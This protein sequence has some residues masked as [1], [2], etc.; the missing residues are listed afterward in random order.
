[1]LNIKYSLLH[2][3]VL[4]MFS[5]SFSTAGAQSEKNTFT[6]E[7]GLFRL[8]NKQNHLTVNN[9][10]FSNTYNFAFGLSYSRRIRDRPLHY[11]LTVGNLRVSR[12]LRNLEFLQN[13]PEREKLPR[14]TIY[15]MQNNLYAIPYIAYQPKIGKGL[16]L[17]FQLGIGLFY[18]LYP[19][20][21]SLIG[22]DSLNYRTVTRFYVNIDEEASRSWILSSAKV[23]LN[24]RVG[25][26][27]G[28]SFNFQ[29]FRA[30]TLFNS[31]PILP[32]TTN[33]RVNH[34]NYI[35]NHSAYLNGHSLTLSYSYVF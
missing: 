13:N 4:F 7:A 17:N 30:I 29:I 21:E 28:I 20:V 14:V 24:Y 3:F 16:S 10:Y 27:S 32:I 31:V 19:K 11:G 9:V 5:L 2:Y 23:G 33:L 8:N 34:A 1:M 6:I 26:R 25:K 35:I 15:V 22:Y 18:Q 12:N